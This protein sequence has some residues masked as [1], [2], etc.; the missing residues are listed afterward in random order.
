W[1]I[2]SAAT[3]DLRFNYSK[4]NASSKFLQDDFGG[5]VPLPS[6][7]FPSPFTSENASFILNI[8][9]LTRS[10]MIVGG[11]AKNSQRQINF[12]DN[13]VV[14]K[15][16]HSLKFGLDFRRLTPERAQ[17]LY[18]QLALFLNV[19]LAKVGQA[20]VGGINSRTAVTVL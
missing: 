5:A 11:N 14:Q 18:S 6:L 2:S 8:L 9:P 7:P 20:R 1:V 15:G 3:N 10:S 16:S 4:V 19:A 13:V 17:P 12:V